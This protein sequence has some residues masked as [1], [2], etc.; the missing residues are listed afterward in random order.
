MTTIEFHNALLQGRG[1]C[2]QAVREDPERYR[3]EVLWACRELTSFDTQCEGSKAW[4][5]RELVRCYDDPA[6]FV[7]AVCDALKGCPSDGSWHLFCLA[8]LLEWFFRDGH[9][10]AWK[11]L[12]DKYCQLYHELLHV[13]PPEDCF[14]WAPGGDF[15]K[16]CVILSW[17]R[18]HYL[19]IA[20]D[21][22]RLFV[23]T[24]WFDGWDFDWLYHT[25]GQ[26]YRRALERAAEKDP[27]IAAYIRV[28]E[29][30]IRE[31][32]ARW[33]ARKRK[34]LPRRGADPEEAAQAVQR[35]LAAETTEE[36]TAALDLFWVCPYPGEPGPVIR[37]ARSEDEGLHDA[38]WRVLASMQ[39]P[40]VRSFA[41]E[42]LEREDDAFGVLAANYREA[43]EDRL[44][45]RLRAEV[46]D[47]ECNTWWHRYQLDVL[48]MKKPPKAALQ[49]IFDTTYCSR[50]RDHALRMMG[51]R[52]MLTG[53]MLEEC[54][55]DSNEDI[56]SYARR[57]MKRRNK[58]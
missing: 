48:N 9:V 42:M 14:Y 57:A 8:E 12:L 56:R 2:V 37:D 20:H 41:L 5:V 30:A 19:E 29:E 7:A 16:L 39:H 35:Y 18:D 15:G 46:I 38:A 51:K 49:Y 25:K 13:G 43:D 6:P 58:P 26:R 55:Y 28:H 53:E 21:I 17:C 40:D 27:Y 45:A 54:L 1:N 34:R 11:A 44:M 31:D 50:C 3:E 36:R 47:F 22:G 33:S 24:E 10:D 52:R 23:E 4:F 32:E